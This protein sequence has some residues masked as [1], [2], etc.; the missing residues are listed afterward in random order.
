MWSHR[1]SATP[2]RPCANRS[3][4]ARACSPPAQPAMVLKQHSKRACTKQLHVRI[5]SRWPLLEHWARDHHMAS[6]CQQRQP[7]KSSK[8]NVKVEYTWQFAALHKET[9][10]RKAMCP[11]R[12]AYKVIVALDI[13]SKQRLARS[14]TAKNKPQWAALPFPFFPSKT[15]VACGTVPAPWSRFHVTTL[16]SQPL[17]SF[18]ENEPL[19]CSHGI[20]LFAT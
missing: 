10:R 17:S 7:T 16:V 12:C 19:L 1:W 11:Q 3:K 18:L 20:W 8:T 6:H 14:T 13:A 9:N 15:I 4:N 5:K 2:P